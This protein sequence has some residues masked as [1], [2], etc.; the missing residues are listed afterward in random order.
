M[1]Q[2]EI[3]ELSVEDIREKIEDVE[4]GQQKLLLSHAVSI[5][6]NPIQLRFNRRLIARLKT[7]LRRRELTENVSD[8]VVKNK[9]TAEESTAE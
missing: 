5:L 4:S 7:E 2:Q 6:Q 9:A 1:K 8:A 3:K